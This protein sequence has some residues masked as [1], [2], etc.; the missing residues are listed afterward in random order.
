MWL[1]SFCI[2]T[3]SISQILSGSLCPVILC[4]LVVSLLEKCRAF[5]REAW[6]SSQCNSSSSSRQTNPT[7]APTHRGQ[8]EVKTR[9]AT[10]CCQ[11]F[12]CWN[13]LKDFFLQLNESYWIYFPPISQNHLKLYS[14]IIQRDSWQRW[15]TAFPPGSLQNIAETCRNCRC[16]FLTAVFGSPVLPVFLL[17]SKWG[18]TLGPSWWGNEGNQLSTW[19]I[20]IC[21]EK[22]PC[23]EWEVGSRWWDE[24]LKLVK[25]T[26]VYYTHIND[27]TQKLGH[28]TSCY[29]AG[30]YFTVTG[31]EG[32]AQ[33]VVKCRKLH[34]SPQ[35]KLARLG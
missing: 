2:C 35:R 30:K 26:V 19:M 13:Y 14:I 31:E 23:A 28:V 17:Y 6:G 22:R 7:L 20:G 4:H 25:S 32:G 34:L 29:L 16:L 12:S 24:F 1:V 21:I 9:P 33:R 27:F 8:L 10:G 18:P 3:S 11:I 5:F 15:V